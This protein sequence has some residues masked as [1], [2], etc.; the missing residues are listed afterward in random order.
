MADIVSQLLTFIDK[1]YNNK[2]SIADAF[3]IL[4][5]CMILAETA[6]VLTG[7]QKKQLV[8]DTL[9]EVLIKRLNIPADL[10]TDFVDFIDRMA[11]KMIDILCSDCVIVNNIKSC[12]QKCCHK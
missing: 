11:S 3:T 7:E 12:W 1:T 10:K 8:L 9:H 6:H 5:Q 2:P 4:R